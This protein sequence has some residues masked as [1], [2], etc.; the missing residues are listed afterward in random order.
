M[1]VNKKSN[2]GK[3]LIRDK[4]QKHIA[5][6]KKINH[7]YGRGTGR[8]GDDNVEILQTNTNNSITYKGSITEQSS[9]DEFLATAE[10]AGLQFTAERDNAQIL[11]HPIHEQPIQDK[12]A[13]KSMLRL[14]RRPLWDS[15][16]S[17]PELD[18][19][20][21]QHFLDWRR[22]L[23]LFQESFNV[24]LTPYEKNL[25]MWRQL[26]RVIEKS[27]LVVQILDA[28]NPLLFYCEDLIKYVKESSLNHGS[29]KTMVLI[30]KADFLTSQ[31]RKAWYDYFQTLSNDARYV[32]YSATQQED[33]DSNS[34][35][36]N[37]VTKEGL[38]EIFESYRLDSSEVFMIGL[39]GY[40][41]VGKS[42]TI[43]SLLSCKRVSVSST[44]GKTKH[45]QTIFLTKNLCLCDC[46]GLVLPNF[47]SSKSELVVNGIL[48]IDE[49]KD[50]I[51][52][53]QLVAERIP[54][55]V[56]EHTYGI[57]LSTRKAHTSHSLS[58]SE[59]LST[60]ASYRGFSTSG[61]G[62]PDESR[63]SRHI[64]KDYVQGKLLYCHP[65]PTFSESSSAFNNN[66]VENDNIKHSPSVTSIS[67]FDKEFFDQTNVHAVS[68]GKY[69]KK[70]F[71]RTTTIPTISDSI[72]KKHF[73]EN[74]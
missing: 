21:K 10:L 16:T 13:I 40:P 52:P 56:L 23:A 72:N 29:K 34:D 32:F 51:G 11:D 53:C 25:E 69:A 7:A 50:Y 14:P 46:P 38:L 66:N 1:T 61:F 68:L 6:K 45:F 12:E 62:N 64:L 59:L 15:E 71:T 48:P 33:M 24:T 31:Q 36:T 26:W 74:K 9:L 73:K 30:N 5:S 67:L 2:L 47:A 43:N 4:F 65:P 58:A 42:S 39:I 17:A 60:Y 37:I 18:R 54:I 49:L 35:P 27:Q 20:E 41:N 44:P 28:R 3:S 70:G 19:L 63:A 8:Y 57:V 22:Q 55:H